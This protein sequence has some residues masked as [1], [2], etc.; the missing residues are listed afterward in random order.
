MVVAHPSHE[1]RLH[2]WLQIA[3][4]HVFV[5]TDGS[6]RTG[7]SRL[8]ATTKV[9]EDAGA[10]RGTIYGRFTDLDVYTAFLNHDYDLFIS[11]AEEL[12]E[13]FDHHQVEYVV[14]DSAEGYN[15][16]HDACRL[17]MNAAIE[18]V[19]RKFKREIDNFDYA[20]VGQPEECPEAIRPE[21]IWL[22]L[23]DETFVRK[24]AAVKAYNSKL[25]VDVEA[26][27]QGE[28]FQ[29]LKRFSAPQLAGNVDADLVTEL[30]KDSRAYPGM[31]AIVKGA[32]EGI[33]LD[34]FRLEC[35]R[36]VQADMNSDSEEIRF[37]EMYGEKMVAAGHYQ[38]AIRYKEHFLPLVYAVRRY[39]ETIV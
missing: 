2:G 20:V 13:Q 1:L 25:A 21:A 28:T 5:L 36:P 3:R 30:Q 10:T 9:L 14:G 12:A 17:V 16:T 35:L 37:Y 24:I 15:S 22:S 7:E 26:A 18:I 8:S 31:D 38:A 4:P 33:E 27:L 19:R 39:V 34:R 23:D 11:L 29:G 6:G 32:F